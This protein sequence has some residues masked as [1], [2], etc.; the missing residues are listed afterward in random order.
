MSRTRMTDLEGYL[1]PTGNGDSLLRIL[2]DTNSKHIELVQ[3][4]NNES[5]KPAGDDYLARTGARWSDI[6]GGMVNLDARRTAT[7]AAIGW[8]SYESHHK[9]KHPTQTL[10]RARDALLDYLRM[11]NIP[12]ASGF[13]IKYLASRP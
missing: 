13:T 8:S 5:H 7:C 2:I 9:L 11:K 10:D 12:H 4:R 3:P 6:V 1:Q